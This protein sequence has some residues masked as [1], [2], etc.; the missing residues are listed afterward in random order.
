MLLTPS[1]VRLARDTAVNV[2]YCVVG[3]SVHSYV[4]SASALVGILCNCFST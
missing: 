4:G 1:S 3:V 2:M